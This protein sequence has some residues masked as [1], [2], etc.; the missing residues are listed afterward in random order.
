MG[1]TWFNLP[2]A[3][4]LSKFVKLQQDLG[5]RPLSELGQG[6]VGLSRVALGNTRPRAIRM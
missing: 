2:S 3:P 6:P 4:E 5:G 1:A